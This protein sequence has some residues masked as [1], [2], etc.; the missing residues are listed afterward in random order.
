MIC[1][2]EL[3]NQ[4]IAEVEHFYFCLFNFCAPKNIVDDYIKVH[5]FMP[6]LNNP[7]LSEKRTLDRIIGNRINVTYV[8]PW[9]RR[10]GRRHVL[11]AKL[12]IIVYLVE[13]TG[14][15][16]GH[17]RQGNQ[18]LPQFLHAFLTGVVG[19]LYGLYIKVVYGLF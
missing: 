9:L 2:K 4:L 6:E 19:L 3:E 17:M 8:E 18:G 13:C 7:P 11:S 14:G 12:L 10:K 16:K 15:L 1:S 5:N